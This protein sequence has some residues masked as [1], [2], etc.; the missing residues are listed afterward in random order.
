MILAAK[1]TGRN[2]N[3]IRHTNIKNNQAENTDEIS[4]NRQAKQ[5]D[6]MESTPGKQVIWL[7]FKV[8]RS[9]YFL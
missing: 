2:G 8:Y 3:P 7:K 1:H 5:V 6:S 9:K 4:T